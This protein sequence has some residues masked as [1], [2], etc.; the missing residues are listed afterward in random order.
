MSDEDYRQTVHLILDELLAFKSEF[1]TFQGEVR[2]SFAKV[3]ARFEAV[4]ARFEAVDVRFDGLEGELRGFKTEVRDAIA[5][6][7][8]QA[9]E[10]MALESRATKARLADIERRLAALESRPQERT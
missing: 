3:D 7:R 9:R 4:D 6:T 10:D 8:I 1:R 5:D 2:D